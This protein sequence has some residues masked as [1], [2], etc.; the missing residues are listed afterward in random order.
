MLVTATKRA[1]SFSI[2]LKFLIIV[3]NKWYMLEESSAGWWKLKSPP[4]DSTYVV[5]SLQ[6]KILWSASTAS[7]ATYVIISVQ[8]NESIISKS[9]GIKN[10][11]IYFIIYQ[12]QQEKLTINHFGWWMRLAN[13]SA[14]ISGKTSVASAWTFTGSAHGFTWKFQWILALKLQG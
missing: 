6:T 4:T 10:K 7:S 5:D 14:T 8:T 3:N 11:R 13:V 12:N 9:V 1:R 2:F